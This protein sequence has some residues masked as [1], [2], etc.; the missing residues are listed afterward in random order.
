M[1]V[2]ARRRFVEFTYINS[3]DDKTEQTCLF[4]L[5]NL[6]EKELKRKLDKWDKV[7]PNRIITNVEILYSIKNKE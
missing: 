7:A 1:E 2:T 4:N 6:N 3:L 5:D